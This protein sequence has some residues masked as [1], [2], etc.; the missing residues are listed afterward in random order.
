[1]RAGVTKAEEGR[2]MGVVACEYD[3]D[4]WP[5]L[6]VTKG[7]NRNFLDRNKHDGTFTDES[8]LAGTG[9]DETG[10]AEGSMG[11]DFGDYDRDGWLDLIVANSVTSDNNPFGS[12][13][14][15]LLMIDAESD[16]DLGRDTKSALAQKLII[17]NS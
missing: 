10:T 3:N 13:H 8:L 4:R 16:L 5:D 14:N 9:Y 2:V 17:E 15:H 12:D 1:M 6:Y 7:T 11:V